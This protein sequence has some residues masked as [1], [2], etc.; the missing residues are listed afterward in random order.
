MWIDVFGAEV[1]NF[2]KLET[3]KVPGIFVLIIER[4]PT[5]GSAGS[6]V[7]HIGMVVKD[8]AGTKAKLA[9][10]N[11]PVPDDS[12]LVTLPDG[13]RMELLEDK[14]LAVPAA[15]HHIQ[16][17]TSDAAAT[18]AWYVTTFGATPSKQEGK[19]LIANFPAGSSFLELNCIFSKIPMSKV[20][21]LKGVPSTI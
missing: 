6:T 4:E 19:M 12:S 10:A 8:L 3:Y 2:G 9:A 1:V 7:D 15:F 16:F 5:G 11:V 14:E 20:L 18:Q 21:R 17:I 13:I